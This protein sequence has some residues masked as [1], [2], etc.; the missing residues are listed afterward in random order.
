MDIR[1][2]PEVM[3]LIVFGS[4]VTRRKP[5]AGCPSED[6]V[7]VH[8]RHSDDRTAQIRQQHIKK[9]SNTITYSE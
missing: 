8:N 1:L 4:L 7:T 2:G 5:I 3:L 6:S 9:F